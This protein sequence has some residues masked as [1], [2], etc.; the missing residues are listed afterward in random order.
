MKK[1]SFLYRALLAAGL[2]FSV[3]ACSDDAADKTADETPDETPNAPGDDSDTHRDPSDK[4]APLDC[5]DFYTHIAQDCAVDSSTAMQMLLAC[6]AMTDALTP[7]A[8]DA[9]IKCI[10]DMDCALWEDPMAAVGSLPQCLDNATD[11]VQPTDE[12]EALFDAVC[13]YAA[14]CTPDAELDCE[15]AAPSP[16]GDIMPIL[17]GDLLTKMT[18]CYPA[19]PACTPD[20]QETILQCVESAVPFLQLLDQIAL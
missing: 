14:A 18:D 17:K 3:A 10:V 20:E 5:A 16:I 19:E 6:T 4:S 15:S 2:C 1:A 8:T 11:N 13:D 12:A 9:L 7:D